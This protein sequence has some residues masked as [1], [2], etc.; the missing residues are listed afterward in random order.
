MKPK[1]RKDYGIK[2]VK[3]QSYCQRC[4]VECFYEV[5]KPHYQW[6]DE[7]LISIKDKNNE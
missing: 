7:I 2:L 3:E 1:K 4:K 5:G 6:C